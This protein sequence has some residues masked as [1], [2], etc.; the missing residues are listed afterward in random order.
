MPRG[1]HVE[2]LTNYYEFKRVNEIQQGEVY[3]I[4]QKLLTP[5]EGKTLRPMSLR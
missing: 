2:V 1:E 5:S 3:N 4:E